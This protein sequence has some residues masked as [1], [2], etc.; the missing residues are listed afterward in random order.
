M[1]SMMEFEYCII[2]EVVKWPVVESIRYNDRYGGCYDDTTATWAA[3]WREQR[4]I[5]RL[6]G[7]SSSLFSYYPVSRVSFPGRDCYLLELAWKGD[8]CSLLVYIE[9]GERYVSIGC[10]LYLLC[11]LQFT[12]VCII[13]ALCAEARLEESILYYAKESVHCDI[14]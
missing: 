14:L 11:P 7:A 13:P 1:V 8:E 6:R 10:V 4:L 2:I 9:L 5:R 3:G 12:V